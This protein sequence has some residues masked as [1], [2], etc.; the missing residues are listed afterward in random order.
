[1][2]VCVWLQIYVDS[3]LSV[4]VY[5]LVCWYSPERVVACVS[6][7]IVWD[8]GAGGCSEGLCGGVYG[9][10]SEWDQT[11]AAGEKWVQTTHKHVSSLT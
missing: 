7:E 2:I 11:T 8:Q 4:Y 6:E 9:P 10:C 1:M 5:I 3:E